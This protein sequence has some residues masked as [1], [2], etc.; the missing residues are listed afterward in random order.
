[1]SRSL[2]MVKSYRRFG[3]PQVLF[4]DRLS[5]NMKEIQSLFNQWT[6]RNTPWVLKS[7]SATLWGPQCSP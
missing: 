7:S 1:M 6:R 5:V 3:A 4:L 2:R